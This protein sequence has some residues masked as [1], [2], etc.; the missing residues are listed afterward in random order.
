MR[1][2]RKV[3]ARE[4]GAGV[5]SITVEE[6]TERAK[7]LP[8]P[9]DSVDQMTLAV[10]A[11]SLRAVNGVRREFAE[12]RRRCIKEGRNRRRQEASELIEMLAP[13]LLGIIG[14]VGFGVWPGDEGM[15]D[16]RPEEDQV[17][18]PPEPGPLRER[19]EATAEGCSTLIKRWM[20]ISQCFGPEKK[21]N[22][23]AHDNFTLVRL[24][25]KQPVDA[26]ADPE[27]AEVF[28]ASHAFEEC[29]HS[30]YMMISRQLDQART[31]EFIERITQ[32]AGTR[33]VAGDP[34]RGQA[35]IA[36]IVGRNIARLEARALELRRENP[37]EEEER[38][39]AEQFESSPAAVKLR[40]EEK[41]YK[42]EL[43]SSIKDLEKWTRGRERGD[44]LLR[45]R[46][47]LMP[48]REVPARVYDAPGLTGVRDRW[49][50]GWAGHDG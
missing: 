41:K 24:L 28:L 21:H 50:K 25:G 3:R 49:R 7:R 26:L 38:K 11:S 5:E 4:A 27:I 34:E 35:V 1:R 47:V 23:T 13:D 40:E 18:E 22:W 37:I 48:L 30:A 31:K 2:S 10:I 42:R 15:A 8:A 33:D 19:L 12:E 6:I 17:P 16:A 29:R 14:G 20:F 9:V 46:Q 32:C 39:A 44:E 43:L 45:R 36:A